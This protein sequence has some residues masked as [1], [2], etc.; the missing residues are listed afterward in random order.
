MR[1]LELRL[2]KYIVALTVVLSGSLGPAAAQQAITLEEAVAATLRNDPEIRRAEARAAEQEAIFSQATGAFDSTFFADARLTYDVQEVFGRR[3]EDEEQRRLQLTIAGFAVDQTAIGLRRARDGGS[4]LFDECRDGQSQVI[5]ETTQGEVIICL[6]SEAAVEA[7][8]LP[9]GLDSG[10]NRPSNFDGRPDSRS[11][12]PLQLLIDL[13]DAIGNDLEFLGDDIEAALRDQL[14]V[15]A[16]QLG[17]A[18]ETLKL[19][20]QRLGGLPEEEQFLELNVLLSHQLRFK[21]GLAL[22]T[23]FSMQGTEDNFAGKPLNPTFGDSLV[24]NLFT[25]AFGTKLDVPL[26]RGRGKA[27]AG[28]QEMASEANW[29]SSRE[30]AA[31]VASERT[32]A[33]TLAYWRLAAAQER[34]AE[35]EQSAERQKKILDLTYELVEADEMIRAD[36]RRVEATYANARAAVAAARRDEIQGRFDLLRAMGMMA[37]GLDDAPRAAENLALEIPALESPDVLAARAESERHDLLAAEYAIQ[38]SKILADASKINLRPEINLSFQAS[39]NAFHE[40]F[41]D[42]IYDLDGYVEA[43][44]GTV[45]GPS[46]GIGLRWSIPV[47]NHGARGRLIQAESSLSR[48]EILQADLMR[49]IRLRLVELD[50]EM[51]RSQARLAELRKSLAAQERTLAGTLELFQV[52]EVSLIDTLVTE[53]DLTNSRLEELDVRRRIAELNAQAQFESG[54]L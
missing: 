4:L 14:R 20:R 11:Q 34:L 5:V 10:F 16:A 8:V 21:N 49:R 40:S 28:A 35:L 43:A 3:F 53:N 2:L 1:L 7:I 12:S 38:A 15:I 29:E 30:I 17:L 31:H 24:P 39:F 51:G 42:R 18:A 33:T 44:T 27:A 45:A 13:N 46:F 37:S 50:G 6:S 54:A 19:Q 47:K 23:S 48:S 41:E 32:L 36:A 22:T 26:A 52:G 9:G 25:T